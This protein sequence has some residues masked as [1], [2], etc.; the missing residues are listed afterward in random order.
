MFIL[1]EVHVSQKASRR[2]FP[3]WRHDNF[4]TQQ[5]TLF[6]PFFPPSFF[7]PLKTRSRKR[8]RYGKTKPHPFLP[9]HGGNLAISADKSEQAKR[10]GC[11]LWDLL[12]FFLAPS[13]RRWP[14]SARKCHEKCV[15]KENDD[16]ALT[17]FSY[18]ELRAERQVLKT[19]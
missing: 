8:R 15:Q 4:T 12:P 5:H 19:R 16:S 18:L 3:P 9:T 2:N 1:I 11:L 14:K 10:R 13:G 6:P 7:F 17:L